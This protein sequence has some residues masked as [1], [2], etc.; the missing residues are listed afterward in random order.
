MTFPRKDTAWQKAGKWYD[1]A[2]GGEGHYYHQRV[3]LPGA[4][5]L[6]RLEEIPQPSLLDLACGQGVL[7]RGLP[8]GV[9]YWGVDAAPALIH[10][11]RRRGESPRRRF[12]VGDVCAP[13]PVSK[14]DF[15]HAAILLALQNLAEGGKAVANAGRHLKPGGRLVIVVNH[16]CFR[17]PR[18]SSW[19]VDPA[20]NLQYRRVNRY[21]SP[22]KV[23]LQVNPSRGE[24]SAVAWSFHHPLSDYS[25]WL[26]EAG[27][28]VERLE[29]WASDK[30]SEGKEARRENLSRREFPLFL[31]ISARLDPR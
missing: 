8:P 29:E 26:H 10:A 19:G 16:P 2:V 20:S 12:L 30:V 14:R 4:L 28:C 13:L 23:P 24:R 22:L 18:Q 17:V 21:L 15:S 25:R 6:L 3:V 11:A 7:A 9:E 5:R 1:R 27:F 31:A